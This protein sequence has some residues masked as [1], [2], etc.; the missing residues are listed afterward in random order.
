MASPSKRTLQAGDAIQKEL[1][2]LI[3]RELRDPRLSEQHKLLSVITQVKVSRDLSV[4]DVYISWTNIN[5]SDDSTHSFDT[6]IDILT[7]AAGFLR[8]RLARTL[9]MRTT[10]ELRFYHDETSEKGNRIAALLAN[11]YPKAPPPKNTQ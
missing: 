9:T 2:H 4:A 7:G 6:L 5:Q 3:R 11:S 8:S 10:P 1:T